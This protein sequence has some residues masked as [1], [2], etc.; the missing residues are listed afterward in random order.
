[1][2]PHQ[3]SLRKVIL[4]LVV[5]VLLSNPQ[6]VRPDV[7]SVQAATADTVCRFGITSP[8]GSDGYDV[9]SIGVGSYLDWG[10]GS[11]PS[12]P[13]GVEYIRVLRLRNDLYPQTLANLPA[14]VLANLGS[15]WVVGNEPDTTYGNKDALLP[16]VY[17]DR[18]YELATIIRKLD[19]S[20]R[21][22]FGS[23]F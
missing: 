20:A 8:L 10:A 2:L 22:A 1:M 17:A 5:C 15:V 4:I 19:P 23:V 3:L 21:M 14:W 16:E 6:I 13:A 9:A 12:L 11:N 7:Q 18:Y